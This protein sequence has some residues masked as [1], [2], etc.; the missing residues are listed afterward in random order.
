LYNQLS[1]TTGNSNRFTPISFSPLNSTTELLSIYSDSVRS[2]NSFTSG[3]VQITNRA[4]IA[5][6]RNTATANTTI[7]LPS[8]SGTLALTSQVL[9]S[10]YFIG[11]TTTAQSINNS[12][13]IELSLNGLTTSGN[14]GRFGFYTDGNIKVPSS[15]IYLFKSNPAFASNSTGYR[16][17]SLQLNATTLLAEVSCRAIYGTGSE[18]FIPDVVS[19][20]AGDT[21]RVQVFQDSGGSL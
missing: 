17:V 20:T 7:T 15:G 14:V 5:S 21:L 10:G 3:N 9:A 13:T 12:S 8:F 18:I 2:V 6:V 19:L 11:E 1:D 4:I 16:V